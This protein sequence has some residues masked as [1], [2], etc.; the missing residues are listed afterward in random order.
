MSFCKIQT[1]KYQRK[2][3]Y[4]GIMRNL[5]QS[6]LFVSLFAYRQGSKQASFQ[7]TSIDFLKQN[8]CLFISSMSAVVPRACLYGVSYRTNQLSVNEDRTL[9]K[10]RVLHSIVK[11]SLLTFATFS[12]TP[13]RG[14]NLA[15]F[16]IITN[17]CHKNFVGGL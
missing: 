16:I 5:I 13:L 2:E 4:Y 17:S 3:E 14:L 12:S 15:Q 7:S 8:G 10:D 9:Q 6:E 1:R 11:Q